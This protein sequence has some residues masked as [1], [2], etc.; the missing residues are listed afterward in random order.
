MKKEWISVK[1]RLPKETGLY[2]TFN[3][4]KIWINN[5]DAQKRKFGV[6]W[7]YTHDGRYVE[8]YRFIKQD[9]VTHWMLLPKN[10]KESE[11]TE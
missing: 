11:D 8:N 1:D 6:W 10:P 5:F 3:E 4:N 9:G 7:H 2:L